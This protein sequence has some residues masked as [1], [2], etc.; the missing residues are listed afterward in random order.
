MSRSAGF[1]VKHDS[2][3]ELSGMKPMRKRW[4]IPPEPDSAV[5][6]NLASIPK[7]IVRVLYHRGIT[8]AESA[9]IFFLND[10]VPLADPFLF[11]DMP[12]AAERILR[13]VRSGERIAIYGDY[14]TDGVTATAM[15]VDFLESIGASVSAYIPSRFEEGYGLSSRSIA[16]PGLWTKRHSPWG[17]N[18]ISSLPIIMSRVRKNLRHLPFSIRN[19]AAAS[20]PKKTFPVWGWRSGSSRH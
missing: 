20:T 5:Y 13:A 8:D 18:W 16:A 14:D 15:L 10:A 6:R 12:K 7:P 11:A 3:G 1:S 4:E 2:A 17:Q 9:R 19:G